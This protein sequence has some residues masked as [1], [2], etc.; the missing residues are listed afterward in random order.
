[1]PLGEPSDWSEDDRQHEIE[2]NLQSLLGYVVRWVD[3]G[4]GCSK[5]PDITGEPL[6]ED[7]ATCRISAQHVTNWMHHGVVTPEQVDETLRRMAKVVDEQ[8]ADDPTYT[9]MAPDFDGDAFLAARAL[10][11][12]GLEQPSGYTEPILHRR[13]A[14]RKQGE[15]TGSR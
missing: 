14:S 9:P 5:V 13:R 4:V 3:S 8:N 11:F 15:L 12:E 6:M 10:V 1:V 7:R 2:N